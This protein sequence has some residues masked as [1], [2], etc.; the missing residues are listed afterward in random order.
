MKVKVWSDGTVQMLYADDH[1]LIQGAIIQIERASNV[2]FNASKQEWMVLRTDNTPLL[3]QGFKRR[4]DAIQAE[5]AALE[6]TL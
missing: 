6:S 5:I 4:A 1:P 3:P 2:V